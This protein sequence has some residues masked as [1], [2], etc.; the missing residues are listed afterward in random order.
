[1]NQNY[2]NFADGQFSVIWRYT[3]NK[4]PTLSNSIVRFSLSNSQQQ[5]LWEQTID[6][7]EGSLNYPLSNL[8]ENGTYHFEIVVQDDAGNSVLRT[9]EFTVIRDYSPPVISC[10]VENHNME[11]PPIRTEIELMEYAENYVQSVAGFR[12]SIQDE[13]ME[14]ITFNSLIDNL[15]TNHIQNIDNY[16]F[17]MMPDSTSGIFWFDA[18][19]L[20]SHNITVIG[21]DVFGNSKENVFN[22]RVYGNPQVIS[23]FGTYDQPS[24]LGNFTWEPTLSRGY[25]LSLIE[26]RFKDTVNGSYISPAQNL[27]IFEKVRVGQEVVYQVHGTMLEHN[28]FQIEA[29]LR[30]GFGFDHFINIGNEQSIQRCSMISESMRYVSSNFGCEHVI[31]SGPEPEISQ[32]FQLLGFNQTI[33]DS[34]QS[35]NVVS[36]ESEQEKIP[37]DRFGNQVNVNLSEGT[38]SILIIIEDSNGVEKQFVLRIYVNSADDANL[39]SQLSDGFEEYPI[40]MY[41]IVMFVF[42]ITIL[43]SIIQSRFTKDT[44]IE[45]KSD[46]FSNHK[47][48]SEEE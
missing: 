19:A 11:S 22:I 38:H 8:L 43:T 15:E 36:I 31:Y 20:G 14:G 44:D 25:E 13:T 47:H 37:F 26:I 34:N 39:L 23:P 40:F 12:C 5:L 6:S 29:H 27:I 1:M 48:K 33:L 24:V 9:K 16:N 32:E 4:E 28:G 2:D 35:F 41:L 10:W 18:V 17:L 7:F 30:D 45:G 42:I 21:T 3:E 46:V